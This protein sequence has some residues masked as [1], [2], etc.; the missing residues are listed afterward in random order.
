MHVG[1]P[2]EASARGRYQERAVM[3][4]VRRI[5]RM[6]EKDMAG[7][8]LGLIMR[9]AMQGG[10]RVMLGHDFSYRQRVVRRVA[11]DGEHG[12]A[13]SQRDRQKRS[14]DVVEVMRQS[15]LHRVRFAMASIGYSPS[16]VNKSLTVSGTHESILIKASRSREAGSRSGRAILPHQGPRRRSVTVGDYDW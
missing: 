8:F 5:V 12:K 14:H 3:V 10:I 16:R 4:M 13:K 9:M 7:F 6:L 1:Q 15:D 2:A 11:G